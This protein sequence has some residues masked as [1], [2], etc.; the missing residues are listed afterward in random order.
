[1]QA[2]VH[3]LFPFFFYLHEVHTAPGLSLGHEVS[4]LW[5]K[6]L[7][8]YTQL[9]FFIF[10]IFYTFSHQLPATPRLHLLGPIQKAGLM[11]SFVPAQYNGT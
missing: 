7:P 8:V 2:V 4:V 10:F 11:F 3:C 9:F 1:M 5:L 6:R